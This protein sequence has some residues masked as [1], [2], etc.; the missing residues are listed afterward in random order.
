MTPAPSRLRVSSCTAR[1]E[2][3]A[4]LSGLRQLAAVSLEFRYKSRVDALSR[5][6]G[7]FSA[8]PLVHLAAMSR[9]CRLSAWTS[10]A[11]QHG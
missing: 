10:C 8:L 11:A 2:Q 6:C 3:L 9:S 7:A 4:R 5:A 1:A